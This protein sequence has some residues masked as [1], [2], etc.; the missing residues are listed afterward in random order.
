MAI[1]NIELGYGGNA[2]IDGH[3]V[4]VTSGGLSKALNMPFVTPYDTPVGEENRTKVKM[5]D[6]VYSYSGNLS[7]DMSLDAV[8]NLISNSFL[9]R[10]NE[11]DVLI[12]D[13]HKG[14]SISKCKFDSVSFSASVGAL[15]TGTVSFQSTDDFTKNMGGPAKKYMFDDELS[16]QLVKYWHTG[17]VGVES[18]TVSISQSI[19][20]VYLNVDDQDPQYLRAGLWDLTF[21]ISAWDDWYEHQTLKLGKRRINI[22]TGES[23]AWN[24]NYGGQNETGSHSHTYTA[25]AINNSDREFFTIT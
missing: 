2:T 5:G 19:T 3:Y 17:A 10:N 14:Y 9:V 4:L 7:F 1:N 15:F 6:G 13:G 8:E 20:P 24:Y 12:G 18:F 21:E 11:F 25:Y 22:L 16:N 23:T